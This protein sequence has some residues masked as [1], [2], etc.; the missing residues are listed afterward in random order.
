MKLKQVLKT[1]NYREIKE[2]LEQLIWDSE[3]MTA[4]NGTIIYKYSLYNDDIAWV[5]HNTMTD[6]YI[7][8]V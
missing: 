7:L 5:S 1:K 3:T 6:T 2:A 8:R 4:N